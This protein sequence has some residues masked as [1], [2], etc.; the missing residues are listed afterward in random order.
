MDEQA[1]TK[2]AIRL[3]DDFDEHITLTYVELSKLLGKSTPSWLPSWFES[4]LLPSAQYDVRLDALKPSRA[5]RLK[6]LK[7]DKDCTLGVLQTARASRDASLIKSVMLKM[8]RIEAE[9][10]SLTRANGKGKTGPNKGAVTPKELLAARLVELYRFVKGKDPSARNQKL[11]Q[12][13]VSLLDTLGA[14]RIPIGNRLNGTKKAFE[15]AL[16]AGPKV[17]DVDLRANDALHDK[18]VLARILTRRSLKQCEIRGRAP[19]I[20]PGMN[21]PVNVYKPKN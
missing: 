15:T 18:I 19:W 8:S 11:A 2:S 3:E 1:F 20:V 16:S 13:L 4:F 12:A 6:V 10:L 17:D 5:Q 21:G 14:L 9:I 7:L